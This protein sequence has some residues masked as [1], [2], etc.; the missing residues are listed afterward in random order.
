MFNYIS[1]MRNELKW[2][3]DVQY[4]KKTTDGP[5]GV[6]THFKAKWNMS[7]TLDE[8]ITRF[9]PPNNLTF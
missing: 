7:D 6:G 1:D 3:P 8:E 2:N 9:D 5:E 4:M